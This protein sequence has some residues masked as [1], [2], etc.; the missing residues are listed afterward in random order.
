[1]SK[2]KAKRK[3]NQPETLSIDEQVRR[4]LHAD[5][6]YDPKTYGDARH[7]SEMHKERN[8][9]NADLIAKDGFGW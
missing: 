2:A 6:N 1:M 7:L 5:P 4:R 9:R 3:Q 8:R